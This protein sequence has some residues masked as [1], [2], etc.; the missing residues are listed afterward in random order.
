[1]RAFQITIYPTT[2]FPT[3]GPNGG[4]KSNGNFLSGYQ[5][6]NKEQSSELSFLSFFPQKRLIPPWS[7]SYYQGHK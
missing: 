4:K 1:M 6:I 7:S 5:G 2:P 3:Y